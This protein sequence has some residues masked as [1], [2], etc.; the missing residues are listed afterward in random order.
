MLNKTTPVPNTVFEYIPSLSEAE[1][2]LYLIILR[3]TIGWK[4]KQ[5]NSRKVYDWISASQFQSKT[6]LSRRA[7]SIAIHTLSFRNLILIADEHGKVLHTPK[8]RRGKIRL[9]Y[10]IAVD[11]PVEKPGDCKQSCAEFSQD[12]GTLCAALAQKMRIT[13]ETPTK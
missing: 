2:K 9:Y 1:L 6:G 4:D 10:R 12:F 13:K 3:Q 11:T 8:D 7:I 5:K